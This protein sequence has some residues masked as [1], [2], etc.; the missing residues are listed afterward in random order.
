MHKKEKK[1]LTLTKFSANW[2]LEKATGPKSEAQA[3]L[4]VGQSLLPKCKDAHR[5]STVPPSGL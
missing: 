4:E 1:A 5:S 2:L 3:L